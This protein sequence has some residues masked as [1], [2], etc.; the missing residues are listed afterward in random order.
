[1]GKMIRSES[2]DWDNFDYQAERDIDELNRNDRMNICKECD[3]LSTL[4]FCALC[5]CFMPIKVWISASSCPEEK[6]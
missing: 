2:Y 6:W 3:N 4:N 1:M 5:S